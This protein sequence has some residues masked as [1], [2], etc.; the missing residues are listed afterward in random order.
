MA[1]H[2]E[3]RLQSQKLAAA[4]QD[5]GVPARAHPAEG[6]T[7]TSINSELGVAGD[8][9]TAALFEFVDKAL[10]AGVSAPRR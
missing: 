6:K 4:L 8:K 1:E 9:P 2:P 5:A 7:H 10:K 3:V